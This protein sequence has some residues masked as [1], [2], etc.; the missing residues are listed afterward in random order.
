M[1]RRILV[2]TTSES[3]REQVDEVVRVHAGED[4]EVHVVAPASKLSFLQLLTGAIDDARADAAERAEEAADAVPSDRVHPHVGDTD[5]LLAIEDA[6]R[7]WGADEVVVVT[8]PEDEA[9][10]IESGLGEQARKRFALPVTHL[11][12]R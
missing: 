2:V 9:T 3:P 12:T 11:V 5:P 4:A 1:P 6:L 10:W 8:A 7:Q